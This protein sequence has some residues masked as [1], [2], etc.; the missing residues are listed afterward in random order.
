MANGNKLYTIKIDST[1]DNTVKAFQETL[2][3]DEEI[4]ST[5]V[6][7]EWLLVVTKRVTEANIKNR[8]LLLE[9]VRG[10]L[11]KAQP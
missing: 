3:K 11:S 10:R 7:K 1:F 5:S 9:E 4:V 8:N 2:D 6:N